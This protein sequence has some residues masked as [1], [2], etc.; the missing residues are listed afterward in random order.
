MPPLI[1]STESF[2]NHTESNQH[3]CQQEGDE[4]CIWRMQAVC[5]MLA[6]GACS[7]PSKAA[8]LAQEGNMEIMSIL[9]PLCG[10]GL[11]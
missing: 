2:Q 10:K 11:S 6:Q 7:L 9:D 5:L 8:D 1:K 3:T 4:D